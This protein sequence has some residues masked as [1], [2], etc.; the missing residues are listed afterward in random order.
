MYLK[1]IFITNFLYKSVDLSHIWKILLLWDISSI[2]FS[3]CK[4][5]FSQTFL[6]VQWLRIRLPMQGTWVWSVVPED[7]TCPG[8][9]KPVRHNYWGCALEPASH[10]YWACVPQLLKPACLESEF[11]NKRSHHSEKPARH[12]KA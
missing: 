9:T 10:N 12:N 11:H 4:I 7:P 1:S 6:V 2:H 5:Y 8:A 3:I